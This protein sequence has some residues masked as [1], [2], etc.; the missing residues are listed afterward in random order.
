MTLIHLLLQVGL[1]KPITLVKSDAHMTESSVL[2]FADE[3]DS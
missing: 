1:E 2:H 3:C